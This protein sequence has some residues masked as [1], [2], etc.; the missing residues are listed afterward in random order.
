MECEE[1]ER[2]F[3]SSFRLVPHNVSEI[4]ATC[5]EIVRLSEDAYNCF[6]Y[7]GL[8]ETIDLF[9]RMLLILLL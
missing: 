3:P 5:E 9:S 1:I 7:L 4:P 8:V 6:K 2:T